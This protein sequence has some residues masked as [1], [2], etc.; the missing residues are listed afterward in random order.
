[1]STRRRPPAQT[2]TRKVKIKSPLRAAYGEV[3]LKKGT[4]LYRTSYEPFTPNPTKPMVFMLFHPSEW[5]ANINTYITHITIK[6]DI[7]LLFMVNS[8][9]RMRVFPLLNTLIGRPRNNLAKCLDLNLKCYVDHLKKE[10]FHGWLSSIE[11]RSTVEVAILNDPA[12]YEVTAN[13]PLLR[14]WNIEMPDPT[15]DDAYMPKSWGSQYPVTP[16]PLEFYIHRRYKP[17]LDAYEQDGNKGG[18]LYALQI[19]LK[20]GVVR[21]HSAPDP[22][23]DTIAWP[24]PPITTGCSV[25]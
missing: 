4:V 16:I 14:D 15:S 21:Y 17:M 1:M 11:G 8:I 10:K 24:C 5:G 9:R 25:E 23:A 3:I 6:R 18:D 20:R 7:S 12:L 22:P 13:E 19:I 2:Q